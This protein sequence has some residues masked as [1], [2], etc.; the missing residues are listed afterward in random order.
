MKPDTYMLNY[1]TTASWLRGFASTFDDGN[2][3]NDVIINRLRLASE[4]LDEV[5][6]EYA[7]KEGLK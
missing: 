3:Y 7:K 2:K 6:S 1:L 5:W 4:L